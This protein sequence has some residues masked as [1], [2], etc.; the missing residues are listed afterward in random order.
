MRLSG[1]VAV[2]T[3][4]SRGIGKAIAI[5]LAKEGADIAI[6]ARTMEGLALAAKLIRKLGVGCL[7]VA[8]DVGKSADVERLFDR[9]I[10]EFGRIDILV[11]NAGVYYYKPLLNTTEKD[12]DETVGTN[13][14]GV[15]L[16]T[17]EAL[18]YIIKDRGGVIVNISS[19]G[20]KRGFANFSAYCASKFGVNGF[21]QSLAEELGH[22]SVRV[23]AV[24]PGVV[25]TQT[26]R[27]MWPDMD[28][29]EILKP[30]HVAEKVLE[31]CMPDCRVKSG[32]AVDIH[33]F[34]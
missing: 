20:G 6:I 25:D 1:R 12:W 3:G 5:A 10:A 15:Y 26:I 17:K 9:V 7:A 8:G 29:S 22:K 18:P 2:V 14:K 33:K 30:E 23:Y 34:Y 27:D 19:G 4:G 32:A 13:L 24:C 31:L 11:N 16:C 28:P 21:T